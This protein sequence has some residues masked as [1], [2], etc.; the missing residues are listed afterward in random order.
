MG[1]AG[2]VRSP[3]AL[4]LTDVQRR[5]LR[6]LADLYQQMQDVRM[7]T[8]EQLRAVLQQRDGP[9]ASMTGRAQ[10]VD[11]GVDARMRAIRDGTEEGPVP[12]LGRMYATSWANERL[13]LASMTRH[14]RTHPAWPWLSTVRGIGPALATRLLARL[15]VTRAPGPASFWAYCGL[16]TVA[17][18]E[19]ACALCGLRQSAPQNARVGPGHRRR[20][21]AELCRGSLERVPDAGEVRCAP[22]RLAGTR[23][24]H[25]PEARRTCYLVGVSLL[26]CG[27][28]YAGVYGAHKQRLAR[29]RVGWTDHRIHFGA[30]RIMQKTFL[31]DLWIEWRAAV[32]LNTARAFR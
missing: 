24:T 21:G 6:I 5:D 13:V 30:L 17:A 3:A 26:R 29:E 4:A 31:R 2:R 27:S 23:L 11:A 12:I 9:H 1:V 7:R 20:G 22:R 25:D 19:Y 8:G 28:D 10:D 16:S 15:D 18:S 32:G 14:V